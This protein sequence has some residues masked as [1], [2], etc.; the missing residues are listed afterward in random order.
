MPRVKAWL[1]RRWKTLLALVVISSV[2][3]FAGARWYMRV[4]WGSVTERVASPTGEFEVV[5]YEFTA[6]IDPGWTLAIEQVD[7][8][9]REWFW[10]SVEGPGPESIRF[11]ADTTIEVIDRRGGRYTVD[12]DPKT[13]EPSDRYCLN[14][15][16]CYEDPWDDF[17]R[18]SP[19]GD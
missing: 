17:T 10:R 13:L 3:V 1:R 18:T 12:F 14:K 4:D 15:S 11:S 7:G 2:V 16:Y 19:R 5:Q 9:R 6:V 8:D